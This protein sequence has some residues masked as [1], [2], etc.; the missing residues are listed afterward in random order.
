MHTVLQHI[1]ALDFAFSVHVLEF[2]YGFLVYEH[3]A[4]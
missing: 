2:Q 4:I 1:V 3:K